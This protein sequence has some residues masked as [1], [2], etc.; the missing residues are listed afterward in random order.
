MPPCIGWLPLILYIISGGIDGIILFTCI[1]P[2][3]PEGRAP[4]PGITMPYADMSGMRA[5][6]IGPDG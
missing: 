4:T 3:W 5:K 2:G 6:F 1:M